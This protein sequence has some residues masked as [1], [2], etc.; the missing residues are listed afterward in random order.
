MT[1]RRD[2]PRPRFVARRVGLPPFA[3]RVLDR[4]TH[5][6]SG[7]YSRR[8][9]LELAALLNGNH[10]RRALLTWTPTLGWSPD[11]EDEDAA[12]TR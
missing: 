3:W 11:L 1:G 7:N 5:L 9:A 12:G 6:A 10:A 8:F 2:D 4:D